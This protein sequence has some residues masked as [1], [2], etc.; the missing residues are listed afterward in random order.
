MLRVFPIVEWSAQ[1]EEG[2]STKSNGVWN[3]ERDVALCVGS[4]LEA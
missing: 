4:R 2:G 1:K 3:M